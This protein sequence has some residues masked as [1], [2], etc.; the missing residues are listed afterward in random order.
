[1]AGVTVYRVGRSKRAS[2]GCAADE[3]QGSWTNAFPTGTV[4]NRSRVFPGIVDRDQGN[5]PATY[6]PVLTSRFEA[7]RRKRARVSQLVHGLDHQAAG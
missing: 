4:L 3:T 5:T 1:M 7:K 2:V 6:A